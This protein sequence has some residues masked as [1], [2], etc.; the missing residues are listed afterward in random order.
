MCGGVWLLGSAAPLVGAARSE[1]PPPPLF[2]SRERLPEVQLQGRTSLSGLALRSL[3]LLL[4][5]RF[6]PE[7]M[8]ALNGILD[9]P[10]RPSAGHERGDDRRLVRNPRR[11]TR[12]TPLDGT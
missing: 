5:R 3:S 4:P 10:P 6:N 9:A 11:G 2:S 8:A 7:F 1:M 12:S